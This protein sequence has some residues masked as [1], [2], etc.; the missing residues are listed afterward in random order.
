MNLRVLIAS[1]LAGI[2]AAGSAFVVASRPDGRMHVTVLNTGSSTAVLVRTGDGSTVLVDGGASAT[3]LL[4]ALGRVLPPAT[5]HLDMVVITGGEEAAVD[6]LG[7]LPGHYTVGTVVVSGQLNPGGDNVVASLETTG[8]NV[9]EA[10]G[11]TW[12]FGGASWRCLGFIALA[13]ARQMCALSVRDPTGRLLVLGDTGTADQENLC[14]VYGSALDADLV[15][16]PP[17]GAIS[18]VLLFT[19]QPHELAVP[20]AAGVPAVPAPSGYA[21]DRTSTDGDLSYTGGP[22]GL[23][24]ST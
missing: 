11:G 15:V 2:L 16:T 17:G 6:G 4:A 22:D 3:A 19:A 18:P 10:D 24:E 1:V 12:S 23:L 21:V 7:G 5:G 8:A 20:L 13:T 9:L 14:A